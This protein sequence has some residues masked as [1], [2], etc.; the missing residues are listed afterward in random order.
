MLLQRGSSRTRELVHRAPTAAVGARVERD[1][2]YRAVQFKVR[3]KGMVYLK[4]SPGVAHQRQRSTSPVRQYFYLI[5]RIA[6]PPYPCDESPRR[7]F[8]EELRNRD[9]SMEGRSYPA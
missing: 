9:V 4:L 5:R 6:V 2:L 8:S 1:S 3:Q 7:R